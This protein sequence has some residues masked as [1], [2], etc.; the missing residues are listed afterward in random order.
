VASRFVL[1]CEEGDVEGIFGDGSY[2]AIWRF[3]LLFEVVWREREE[4][5]R[6]RIDDTRF[7]DVVIKILFI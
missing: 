5:L 3:W 7:L 1:S 6:Y 2:G 4:D